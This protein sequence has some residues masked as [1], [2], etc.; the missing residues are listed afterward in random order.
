M[1]PKDIIYF[2]NAATSRPKPPEV[3]RQAWMEVKLVPTPR[4]FNPDC[5][6]ALHFPWSR[7]SQPG[8]ALGQQGWSSVV[9]IR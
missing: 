8:S 4:E 1:S 3:V 7:P 5:G 2:D 9:Y 6:M